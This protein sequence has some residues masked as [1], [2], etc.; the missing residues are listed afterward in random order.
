MDIV[1]GIRIRG[2][3]TCTTCQYTSLKWLIGW[4]KDENLSDQQ[5]CPV[6]KNLRWLRTDIVHVLME[7]EYDKIG[8]KA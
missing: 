7:V 3:Y 5:V 2:F 4:S 6:C 8:M 1:C